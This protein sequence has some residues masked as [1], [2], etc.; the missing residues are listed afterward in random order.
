[1]V[2][3]YLRK[4]LTG[5]E[6]RIHKELVAANQALPGIGIYNVLDRL[7]KVSGTLIKSFVESKASDADRVTSKAL[8]E[9]YTGVVADLHRLYGSAEEL[10]KTI[11]S[12]EAFTEQNK[13]KLDSTIRTYS[14]LL[15]K[16]Q[17]L[18]DN[19]EFYNA[20]SIDLQENESKSPKLVYDRSED[21]ILLDIKSSKK[22][23]PNSAKVSLSFI[24]G[25]SRISLPEYTV[26]NILDGSFVASWYELL[27]KKQD[28]TTYLDVTQE[29]VS[30]RVLGFTEYNHDSNKKMNAGQQVIP[31]ATSGVKA[32]SFITVGDP[33][34][35][36][37]EVI[38]VASSD[39]SEL[40]LTTAL[41]KKHYPGELVLEGQNLIAARGAVAVI[42]IQFN[43]PT[44]INTLRFVPF[45]AAPLTLLAALMPT[46]TGWGKIYDG[47]NVIIDD[48]KTI[49]FNRCITSKLRIILEQPHGDVTYLNM[50]GEQVSETASWNVIFNNEFRDKLEKNFNNLARN[51]KE[52]LSTMD[53]TQ[54]IGYEQSKSYIANIMKT[55]EDLGNINTADTEQGI[56]QAIDRFH[57]NNTEDRKIQTRIEYEFGLGELEIFYNQYENE[58]TFRKSDLGLIDNP[59][60]VT[61]YSEE[62]LP[63][64]CSVEHYVV[65]DSRE[66]I[67]VVNRL[68]LSARGEVVSKNECLDFDMAYG[69]AFLKFTPATSTV[70]VEKWEPDPDS[71]GRYWSTSKAL[72]VN[73]GNMVY[74]NTWFMDP[75][76]TYTATYPVRSIESSVPS[77]LASKEV[78][79]RATG[80]DE[81]GFLQLPSS[82]HIEYGIIN[83]IENFKKSAGRGAEYILKNKNST[84]WVTVT[85]PGLT[86]VKSLLQDAI[87][88]DNIYYG[89]A[90]EDKLYRILELENYV[91]G[92][93]A[94]YPGNPRVVTDRF[95]NKYQNKILKENLK[96]TPIEVTVDGQLAVNLSS[97]DGMPHSGFIS[98]IPGKLQFRHTENQLMFG[99]A[100][101][102]EVI[103]KYRTKYT[104]LS[105]EAVLKSH[106]NS[107]VW[108]T[109][110]LK[111]VIVAGV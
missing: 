111:S 3:S 49:Q 9:F 41:T 87:I 91:L 19:K 101:Q 29:G 24:D 46:A 42:D 84:N 102:G 78:I 92:I 37:S 44:E 71:D 2:P 62:E 68:N 107:N 48:I 39:N 22:V 60:V 59:E 17:F 90:S 99:S 56:L 38:K 32:Q 11:S 80:T 10:E 106:R 51:T 73:P 109:P 83:D 52:Q 40:L 65:T 93:V 58:G 47:G 36:T 69:A 20:T 97:Y 30:A 81:R 104:K 85:Q 16:F 72:T 89:A 27:F 63:E 12:Y 45:T 79:T 95:F 67:P 98:G 50:S 74:D 70:T 4:A 57:A 43:R 15:K 108:E 64:G 13:S 26:D 88:V 31:I 76:A 54:V 53:K 55:V 66:V 18:K 5:V 23:Q 1:V 103:I 25:G 94:N 110:K 61:V 82:P 14:H 100:F 8:N 21:G 105:Y 7:Q 33:Y 75:Q 28:K 77:Y 34:K 96:Y 6:E 35:A 86:G